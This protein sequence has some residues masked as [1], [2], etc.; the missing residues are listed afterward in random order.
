[1]AAVLIE[2]ES[3]NY[4]NL[5]TEKGKEIGVCFHAWGRISI[6]IQRA[7]YPGPSAGRRFDTIE[8]AIAA[9]KAADVKS[10]LALLL[11]A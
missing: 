6:Y 4:F 10:A 11:P 1:M 5:T 3:E 8:E 2:Q 7:G 9:Y